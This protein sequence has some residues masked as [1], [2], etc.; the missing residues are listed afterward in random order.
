MIMNLGTLEDLIRCVLIADGKVMITD[1]K[2]EL[3]EQVKNLIL[4]G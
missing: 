1:S 3:K 2:H 4:R